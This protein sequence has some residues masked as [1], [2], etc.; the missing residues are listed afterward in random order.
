MDDSM[1]K[2]TVDTLSAACLL[3]V[4]AQRCAEK[5]DKALEVLV[6]SSPRAVEITIK[7]VKE[8][9]AEATK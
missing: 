9:L 6:N 8:A 5:D 4:T 7:D 1:K 3:M 2:A